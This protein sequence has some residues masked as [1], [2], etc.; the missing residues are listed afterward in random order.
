MNFLFQKLVI[1]EG[2][3]ADLINMGVITVNGQLISVYRR[4]TIKVAATDISNVIRTSNVLFLI[5]NIKYY[6]IILN[7]L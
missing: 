2:F 6:K 7:Y 3:W 4:Y 1:K 5:I